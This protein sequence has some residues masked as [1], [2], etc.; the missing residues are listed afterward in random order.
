M[1]L[2]DPP[3]AWTGLLDKVPEAELQRVATQLMRM[4]GWRVFV[5]RLAWRSDAG[6]PD[7]HGVHP[8]MKR[9][10]YVE[11]K[12]ERGKLSPAQEEWRDVLID[13]CQS[14]VLLRPSTWEAFVRVV[15]PPQLLAADPFRA[16]MADAVAKERSSILKAAEQ[17]NERVARVAPK[18]RRSPKE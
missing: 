13:A 3:L 1:A 4:V 8:V 9:T 18:R 2:T 10:V 17:L 15:V 16:A 6:W 12:T 5:D 14:Y 11:C 7:V